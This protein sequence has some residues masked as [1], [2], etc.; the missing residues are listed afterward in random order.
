[1]ISQTISLNIK[2]QTFREILSLN[3]DKIDFVYIFAVMNV[4]EFGN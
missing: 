1:M 4:I 2:A 3:S